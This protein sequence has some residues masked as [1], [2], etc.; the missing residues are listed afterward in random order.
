LEIFG[1]QPEN[2]NSS[3]IKKHAATKMQ[4]I[5]KGTIK[6]FSDGSRKGAVGK[7]QAA[8]GPGGWG[9]VKEV[10]VGSTNIRTC[11]KGGHPQTTNNAMELTG[12]IEALKLVGK[13]M[14]CKIILHSDSQYVLNGIVNGGN[15]QLKHSGVTQFTGWVRGWQKNDW[16]TSS[17]G[18]V[19]NKELWRALVGA[20]E[21]LLEDGHDLHLQWVKG[22]AGHPGNELADRLANEGVPKDG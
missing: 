19:K 3:E 2:R 9:A 5:S 13:E 1:S 6:L 18:H 14:P 22:H 12:A 17:G 11:R 8:I 15:G 10:T 21:T 4:K 20:C 7:G 16:R